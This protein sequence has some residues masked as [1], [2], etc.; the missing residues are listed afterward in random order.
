MAAPLTSGMAPSQSAEA[1]SALLASSPVGPL[2]ALLPS[3]ARVPLVRQP[4][5]TPSLTDGASVFARAGRASVAP[6]ERSADAAPEPSAPAGHAVPPIRSDSDVLFGGAAWANAAAAAEA[7]QL[8]SSQRLRVLQQQQAQTRRARNVVAVQP[9]AQSHAE[10]GGSARARGRADAAAAPATATAALEL[11]AALD[12]MLFA[13]KEQRTER[14]AVSRRTTHV[15][16][17][18]D[19][20]PWR[21]QGGAGE[22]ELDAQDPMAQALLRVRGRQLLSSAR[23]AHLVGCALQ[24][25]EGIDEMRLWDAV[26][27]H[28]VGP[29]VLPPGPVPELLG[30]R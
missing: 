18:A 22:G 6:A 9:T 5:R 7:E 25:E 21:L 3:S 20:N 1:V 28:A 29:S 2:S 17:M 24:A 30:R 27:A 26:F 23:A 19:A 8:P 11:N 10:E 16:A 15:R 13:W 12:R 4:Q 14:A